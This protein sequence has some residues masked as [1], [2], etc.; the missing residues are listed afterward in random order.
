[1]A[2]PC[3]DPP[4]DTQNTK[5]DR[6]PTSE[7]IDSLSIRTVPLWL[8]RRTHILSP[9]WKTNAQ[10]ILASFSLHLQVITTAA[11]TNI[12]NTCHHQFILEEITLAHQY[13]PTA[14]AAGEHL[15][16]HAVLSMVPRRCLTS[17]P[18]SPYSSNTERDRESTPKPT[19]LFIDPCCVLLAGLLRLPNSQ[20]MSAVYE[21]STPA[22]CRWPKG[23][24]KATVLALGYDAM[25][26]W[27][28][29]LCYS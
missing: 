17:D 27:K 20:S 1:M 24:K 4:A 15:S 6:E 28:C 19:E 14:L 29:V 11:N 26:C 5:R 13:L 22:G 21:S 10:T 9:P 16:T 8:L 23:L 2:P 3:P 7:R 25:M 18:A 12:S